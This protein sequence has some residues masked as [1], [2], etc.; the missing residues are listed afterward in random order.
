MKI[1]ILIIAMLIGLASTGVA[2][3]R[4]RM[5]NTPDKNNL[6]TAIDAEFE[7]S[8]KG[9]GNKEGIIYYDG[10]DLRFALNLTA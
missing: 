4:Y 8:M 10:V 1:A 3:L 5:V 6:E 7:Q 9:G 2:Y